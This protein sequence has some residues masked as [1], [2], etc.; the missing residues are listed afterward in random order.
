M[1]AGGT[2]DGGWPFTPGVTDSIVGEA[3]ATVRCSLK[4]QTYT[5]SSRTIRCSIEM[6]NGGKVAGSVLLREELSIDLI[7]K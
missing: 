2:E 6:V 7:R 4:A 3:L 5:S 1:T